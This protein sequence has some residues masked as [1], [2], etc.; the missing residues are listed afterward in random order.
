MAMT[1]EEARE[2]LRIAM[3][4]WNVIALMARAFA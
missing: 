2:A 3:A 4:V 1:D